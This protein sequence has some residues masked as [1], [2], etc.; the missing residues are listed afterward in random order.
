MKW[1]AGARVSLVA[2]QKITTMAS[3]QKAAGA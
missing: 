3:F 2:A 1:L